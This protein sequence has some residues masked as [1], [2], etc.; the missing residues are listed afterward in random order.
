MRK[1]HVYEY[2]KKDGK[3]VLDTKP[4]NEKT[5][6]D[7]VCNHYTFAETL[8]GPARDHCQIQLARQDVAQC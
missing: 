7:H 5:R 6:I 2:V 8:C 4:Q 3:Y 1:E